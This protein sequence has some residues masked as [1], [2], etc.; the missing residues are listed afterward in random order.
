MDLIMI[1]WIGSLYIDFSNV[2]ELWLSLWSGSSCQISWNQKPTN[3]GAPNLAKVNPK[4]PPSSQKK[5]HHRGISTQNQNQ[6]IIGD[7]Q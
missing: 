5:V 2:I 1:S 3:L 6:R 4:T 7:N